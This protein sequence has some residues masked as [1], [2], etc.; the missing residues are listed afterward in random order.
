MVLNDADGDGICDGYENCTSSLSFFSQ[1][2]SGQ[3]DTGS[4]TLLGPLDSVTFNLNFSGVGASYP[5]DMMVYIYA[6]NGDCV[7]W[8][9]WN[10]A[11]TGGCQNIGTG[12]TIVAGELEH[13]G[14]WFLHVHSQH[15]RIRSEWIRSLVRDH[16]ERMDG[17]VDSHVQLGRHL[18]RIV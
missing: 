15:Q 9:G 13:H 8:G 16:P 18:P 4:E 2:S 7:V 14:Q 11:P 10:I 3:T 5:S 6:P 12:A 1:L 17:F